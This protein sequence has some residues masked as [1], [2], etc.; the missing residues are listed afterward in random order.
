MLLSVALQ[1]PLLAWLDWCTTSA[2]AM[3]VTLLLAVCIELLRT[4]R[5]RTVIS[6]A[7]VAHAVCGDF[8]EHL[9]RWQCYRTLTIS[10]CE[11][12]LLSRE[13][14]CQQC[15]LRPCARRADSALSQ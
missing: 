15:P 11:C 6:L 14:V 7:G 4:R 10:A 5:W 1:N 12:W 9:L 8:D 13:T 2:A 3:L